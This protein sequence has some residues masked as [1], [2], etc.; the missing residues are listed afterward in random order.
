MAL[1]TSG[2]ISMSDIRTEL[3]LSGT[4]TLGN[5][6]NDAGF[7]DTDSMSEFYGYSNGL[8]ILIIQLQN[9]ADY[10]ENEDDT[11]LIINE[12]RSCDGGG[13][14]VDGGLTGEGD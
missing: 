2:A 10:C 12:L 3:G 9:R 5:M 6:S 8:D 13:G 7:S 4:I 14:K 1:Q 11:M